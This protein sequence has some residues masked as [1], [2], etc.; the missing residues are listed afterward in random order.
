MKTRM[1]RK[2]GFGAIGMNRES[3]SDRAVKGDVQLRK[4]SRD[5]SLFV[6]SFAR[7]D[8]DEHKAT[9]DTPFGQGMEALCR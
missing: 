3:N 5:P 9:E 2:G 8:Y 6:C 7:C 1:N 4:G